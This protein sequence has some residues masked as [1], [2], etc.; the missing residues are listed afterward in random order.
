MNDTLA[1]LQKESKVIRDNAIPQKLITILERLLDE[2]R[3]KCIKIEINAF[4]SKIRFVS[5]FKMLKN[6]EI[7]LNQWMKMSK[8]KENQS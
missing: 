1:Y 4:I 6:G 8:K 2:G 7:N 3:E 5:G